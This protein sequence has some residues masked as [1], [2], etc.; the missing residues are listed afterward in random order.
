MRRIPWLPER[1]SASQAGVGETIVR[2]T[3]NGGDE[4]EEGGSGGSPHRR[5]L[6]WSETTFSAQSDSTR[7]YIEL[8]SRRA[9]YHLADPATSPTHLW[10]VLPTYGV[11]DV[12]KQNTDC[13][14]RWITLNFTGDVA[15]AQSTA[16]AREEVHIFILLL[17][18]CTVWMW[19]DLPT[20]RREIQV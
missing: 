9:L 19:V 1:L 16:S 5:L 13:K 3:P 15:E 11:A 2:L 18:L 4:L 10:R 20:F 12:N 8:L 17:G 14:T 7:S 6:T